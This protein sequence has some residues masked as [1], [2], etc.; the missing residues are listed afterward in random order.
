VK[1]EEEEEEEEERSSKG[2]SGDELFLFCTRRIISDFSLS[3][4]CYAKVAMI[5]SKI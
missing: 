2:R 5:H 3:I 4:L 1:Q